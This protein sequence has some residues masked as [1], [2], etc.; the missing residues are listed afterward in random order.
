MSA[1]APPLD[2]LKPVDQGTS[3]SVYAADGSR[4][5]FI[6]SDEIRTPVPLLRVPES[7]RAATDRGCGLVLVTHD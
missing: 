3:S 4:L 5:G 6:Q 2:S 7:L 1:S